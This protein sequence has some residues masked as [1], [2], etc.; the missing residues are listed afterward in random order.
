[1][2]NGPGILEGTARTAAEVVGWAPKAILDLASPKISEAIA[3]NKLTFAEAKDLMG[4]SNEAV[5]EK[6]KGL[7]ANA[8]GY[9]KQGKELSNKPVEC[10]LAKYEALTGSEKTKHFNAHKEEIISKLNKE[11]K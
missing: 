8:T 4:K 1:M 3:D 9:G 7:E 2:N 11:T 6:L 10:V 5:T